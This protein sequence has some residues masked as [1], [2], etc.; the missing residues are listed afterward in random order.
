MI[1]EGPI[2]ESLIRRLAE[3]PADF[4]EE[5]RIG[6][7][8]RIHVAAIVH[9]L[10]E[11]FGESVDQAD[12]SSFVGEQ[13]SRDR[14]RLSITLL[15]CWLLSDPWF[16][17]ARPDAKTLLALLSEGSSELALHNLS[18]KFITNP[19]RREEIIRFTLARL[20]FR[21][22]GETQA[23][24]EDRLTS[25]SSAERSRLLNASREAEKRAREIRKA[26]IEK[27]AQE[28]ADKW[29]RE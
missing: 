18:Q 6:N 13:V 27:A 4:V 20:G 22:A 28:S 7:K 10:I 17:Q 2:L 15:L 8:G 1:Q 19:D 11:S 5:P 16:V 9:D 3:T 14:N 24:A 23:Q 25:I 12:L 29:T 26:L 21:P